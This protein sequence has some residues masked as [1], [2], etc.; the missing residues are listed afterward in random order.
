MSD[1]MYIDNGNCAMQQYVDLN[2]PDYLSR[3]VALWAH[4]VPKQVDRFDAFYALLKAG[5]VLRIAPGV[6]DAI[7]KEMVL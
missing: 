4:V 6:V 3:A 7:Q 1:S 5:A 2:D